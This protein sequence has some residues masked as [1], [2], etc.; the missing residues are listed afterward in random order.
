MCVKGIEADLMKPAI[1]EPIS[2]VASS[3]PLNA[4]E[5]EGS[6]SIK[7]AIQEENPRG[8]TDAHGKLCILFHLGHDLALC[9]LVDCLNVMYDISDGAC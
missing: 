3:M 7:T 5:G 8:K 2:G 4:K 6:M 1:R 9:K